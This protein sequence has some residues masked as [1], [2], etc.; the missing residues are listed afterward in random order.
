M[1]KL[2]HARTHTAA[3]ELLGIG[4]LEQL[5]LEAIS[6]SSRCCSTCAREGP[7]GSS[8]TEALS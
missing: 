3:P 1:G 7:N 5:R 6:G 4:R 2:R 8:R